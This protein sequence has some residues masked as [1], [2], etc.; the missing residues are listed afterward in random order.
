VRRVS[1][2]LSEVKRWDGSTAKLLEV[3]GTGGR[4]EA[5]LAR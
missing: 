3:S 4:R 5:L 1:V 2:L